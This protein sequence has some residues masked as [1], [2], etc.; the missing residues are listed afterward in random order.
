SI[1]DKVVFA[2]RVLVLTLSVPI[3]KNLIEVVVGFL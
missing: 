2:G 1:S 3:I